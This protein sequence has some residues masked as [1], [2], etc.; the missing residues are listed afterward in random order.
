MSPTAQIAWS[1]FMMNCIRYAL[2]ILLST[3]VLACTQQTP[4]PDRVDTLSQ[5]DRLAELDSVIPSLMD[6]GSVTGLSI[7]IVNDS[8]IAWAKG[9]GVRSVE[10]GEPVDE[11]SVF[12]AASLSKPVFAYAVLQLVDEGLLDLDRPIV[13]YWD[14][15]YVEDE[16]FRL[17]TPRMILSHTPGFPNWRPRGGELTINFDPGS[18]FSYSGE[19]FVYLQM[20]VMDITDQTLQELVAQR[21]FEP[22]G[23]TSSGYI[24][25]SRFEERVAMPHD[26]EGSVGRKYRPR[27]GRG[28]ATASL[29]TTASDFARFIHAAMQGELLSDTLALA[30][31][32]PQVE[33][34]TGLTWGLGIGLQDNEY[35]RGFWHWGDNTGYKAYTLAYPE[36]GVG[37]VWFTN[38]ENGQMILEGLLAATVGGEHPAAEWLGYE[39]Y[40]APTRLTR[41]ALWR[42]IEARG[43]KAAI[44]EY[45]DLKRSSPAEAF[46]EYV[47]NS[48]GY[49]LLGEERFGEA[50]DIFKLNVDEYPDAWNPY[51]SLGEAFMRAGQLE[52]AIVY[53]E[54]SLELNPDNTNGRAMLA[55][56]KE[57][58]RSG[59]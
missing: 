52:A 53:Y 55:R 57:Q 11:N 21:V 41:A 33:V 26:D 39:Q 19:G 45:Y 50:I 40:N 36:R 48:L 30:Y 1:Y 12:E 14:Y 16:R 3:S 25:E 4:Q 22:L 9:F 42:T 15:D 44:E 6:S 59:S 46:D 29:H 7:A 35:G 10:T 13:E 58:L 23:M 8:G 32:T 37:M 31:L 43:V 24:W 28:N 49:N 18:E 5:Q 27:A 51:D 20:A 56:I 38:S 2:P 17:I 54:K 47:L 34:D